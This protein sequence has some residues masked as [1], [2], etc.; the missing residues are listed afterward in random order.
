M[1]ELTSY[2][3]IRDQLQY[4]EK[5]VFVDCT[6]E[7]D[8]VDTIILFEPVFGIKYIIRAIPIHGSRRSRLSLEVLYSQ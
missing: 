1:P 7:E 4:E 8:G 3:D 2:K 5:L 6:G